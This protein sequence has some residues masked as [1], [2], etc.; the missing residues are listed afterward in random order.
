MKALTISLLEF[1]YRKSDPLQG[2]QDIIDYAI[3]ADELNFHRF[4]LAEHHK[5]DAT[6]SY[7][8]PDILLALLAGMTSSIRLGSAGVLMKIHEP[9]FIASNYKLLNNLFGQRIDLGFAKGS[10]ECKYII[11]KIF[12]NQDVSLFNK[13]LEETYEL[14]HQEKHFLANQEIVLP[15]YKG[16][17]PDLWYLSNSYHGIRDAIKFKMNYCRSL[18]HS[19]DERVNSNYDLDNLNLYRNL[20]YEKYGFYPKTSLALS[21]SISKKNDKQNSNRNLYN[22]STLKFSSINALCQCMESYQEAYH[23]DEFVLLDVEL[24]NDK[25]IENIIAISEKYNLINQNVA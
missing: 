4:W 1:G 21:I 14:L 12:D 20:F 11:E 3:K 25:K 8:Q 24:D 19:T 6:L 9:Y 2:I 13:K 18:M 23:I 16:S 22:T 15:P 10:P 17:I 7:T 5:D